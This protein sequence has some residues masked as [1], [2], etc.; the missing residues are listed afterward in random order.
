M[1]HWEQ[2]LVAPHSTLHD[3]L[4]VI[5]RTGSQMALV[6][7]A[8]RR[9]LGT[10]S[11][12]DIRR[13][14]LRGV[15]LGDAVEHAMHRGPVCARADDERSVILATM[16]RRGLHQMPVLDAQGRVVGLEI[17][18]DF[19]DTPRRENW[20]V[21]MAGGLGTRLG[22]LTREVPKP[23]LPVGSRPL[24]E[25]IVRCIA[26]HGFERIY[27]AVNYKAEQIEAHFGDGSRLGLDIRYLREQQRLGT[28][29]ALS[30]LPEV[31]KVPLVV[32]NADLLTKEDF[33]LMVDRHVESGA[34]ATM[35]VRPYEMQVPFGVV[36]E[37]DGLIDGI[38]EK[39]LQRFVVSAGIY[40]LSPPALALVPRERCFDMPALFEELIA[41]SMRARCHH[42]RSYWLDIGRLPDY[43]R[44]NLDFA[45]V[46]R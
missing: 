26:E 18:V 6:V 39:P 33:G 35:A 17:Y 21:V 46:F 16:R 34:D 38:E 5:D 8:E 19:F 36:R 30:L 32:T 1:R 31:P 22:A 3:A 40:V 44:A 43:E 24:L 10:L 12:G 11:D 37:R 15:A 27:L 45:E 29:G 7:D 20:V 9:L 14:L 25:T 13:A 4:A 23:M 42:V 41:R 2:V 28:A